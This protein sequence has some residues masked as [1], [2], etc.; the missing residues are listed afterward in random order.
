MVWAIMRRHDRS[1]V[2]VK[3]K[4]RGREIWCALGFPNR[5]SQH[6]TSSG[7]MC[8]NIKHAAIVYLKE[9]LMN[10]FS[11]TTLFLLWLSYF[12]NRATVR[13][14]SPYIFPTTVLLLNIRQFSEYISPPTV[15]P[16]CYNKFSRCNWPSLV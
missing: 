10:A 5:R 9:A 3:G 12:S 2:H 13:Q 16:L 1:C 15:L 8:L 14:F 4:D 7:Q 11:P 6:G